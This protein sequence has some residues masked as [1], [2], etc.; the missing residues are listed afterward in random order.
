[1]GTTV[2]MEECQRQDSGSQGTNS[3]ESAYLFKIVENS[4][5]L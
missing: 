5:T 2:L 1:M 4:H 3:Q